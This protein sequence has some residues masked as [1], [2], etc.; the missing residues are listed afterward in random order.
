MGNSPHHGC[1][2]GIV[3]LVASGVE[4]H[5]RCRTRWITRDE[6]WRRSGVARLEGLVGD[7]RV[8]GEWLFMGESGRVE[9]RLGWRKME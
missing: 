4:S 9:L 5:R 3:H 1:R 7:G 2:S 8:G 6:L